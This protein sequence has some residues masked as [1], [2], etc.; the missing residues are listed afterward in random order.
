MN[1]FSVTSKTTVGTMK[2]ACQE[3]NQQAFPLVDHENVFQGLIKAK[4]L[5]NCEDSDTAEDVLEKARKWDD[6]DI[7]VTAIM[8]MAIAKKMLEDQILQFIPV[9]DQDHKIT[10]TID[11]SS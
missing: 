11:R 4:D 10:G 7:Y 9:L 8:H 3:E 2:K 6:R 5:D 1:Y